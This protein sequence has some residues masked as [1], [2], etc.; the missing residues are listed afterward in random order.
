[1]GSR[2]VIF[3]LAIISTNLWSSDGGPEMESPEIFD[4]YV[5]ESTAV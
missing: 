2:E 1:M 4:S 3:D 5:N